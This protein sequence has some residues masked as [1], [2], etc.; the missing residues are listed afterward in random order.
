MA[1]VVN[2]IQRESTGFHESIGN[3]VGLGGADLQVSN[4]HVHGA[5]GFPSLEVLGGTGAQL[6]EVITPQ[7]LWSRGWPVRAT[8]WIW[9]PEATLVT[10]EIDVA[11][12][13]TSS[14]HSKV[15][16]VLGSDWTLVDLTT[17]DLS[18]A[19][20]SN[21]ALRVTFDPQT[22]AY[23]SSPA[24][25]SPQAIQLNLSSRETWIRLPEY[26]RH[27]DEQQASPEVPLLRFI[28]VLTSQTDRIDAL[29]GDFVYIPPEDNSGIA[30][31]SALTSPPLASEAT[32]RWLACL[33][34]TSLFNPFTG[35]T[36]WEN[37][38]DADGDG[39][40]VISWDDL[41]AAVNAAGDGDDPIVPEWI[42]YETFAPEITGILDFMRWQVSS[43]AYGL[44][45]G[46]SGS[47]RAAAQQALT[48]SKSVTITPHYGGDKFA[49]LIEVLSSEVDDPGKVEEY[50]RRALPAGYGIT[51]SLVSP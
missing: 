9:V 41:E 20:P 8:M 28:D 27:A 19:E 10:V 30:K 21:L 32:L 45:G 5:T 29:W 25:V 33:M 34:G 11:T 6:S 47:V 46:T 2:L 35:L 22:V 1:W 36:P 43:A 48:G 13:T 31:D 23:I 39:D 37:L 50:V 38:Q 16:A 15:H 42:E 14:T 12:S 24:I 26:I 17:P 49:L 40:K 18:D 4:A 51:V 7:G 44:R 3:W